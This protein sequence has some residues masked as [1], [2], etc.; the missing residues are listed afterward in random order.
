MIFRLPVCSTSYEEEVVHVT[1]LQ[2]PQL[3][4]LLLW[5]I[6][7]SSVTP[8]K[9]QNAACN[10]YESSFVTSSGGNILRVFENNVE[11]RVFKLKRHKLTGGWRKLYNAEQHKLCSF[12]YLS[13]YL[14]MALQPLWILACFFSFLIHTCSVGLLEWG[15]S[16]SQCCYLYTEQHK[17]RIKAQRH[18]CLEWDSNPRS[19][20]SSGRRRFIP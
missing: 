15:I 5:L 17:H 19:Q 18:P 12:V 6:L 2:K 8:H 4:D 9:Y 10:W 7:F 13:I 20:C 1:I 16:P 3:E 14:S 11:C